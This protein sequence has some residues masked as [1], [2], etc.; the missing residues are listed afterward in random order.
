[1]TSVINSETFN[2]IDHEFEVFTTYALK[3]RRGLCV[4]KVNPHEIQSSKHS[5][6]PSTID[7]QFASASIEK[8]VF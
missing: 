3:V 2:L 1:M 7:L 4:N 8:T 5:K 6:W